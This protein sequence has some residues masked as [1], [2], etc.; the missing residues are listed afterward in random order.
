[1]PVG[2]HIVTKL[3]RGKPAI[4]YVYAWRGGPLIHRAEGKK[5]KVTTDLTDKAAEE[6]RKHNQA[7]ADTIIG[8]IASFRASAEWGRLSKSQ[9]T[10]YT[11]WL[12]RISDKFGETPLAVFS[13][14]R[15]RADVLEW[16]DQWAHQ[17]RSADVAIQTMSRLLSFGFDRGRLPSNVI[18]GVDRLYEADRSDVIWEDQ[19]IAAIMPHAAVEVQ[20]AIQLALLTGLRRG[21]LIALPWDAVGDHAILWRT[22]KSG[23]RAFVTIPVIEGLHALLDRIKDRHA[24][25]MAGKRADLRK[26]LP[27]TILSN[28]HWKPWTASGFGSRFNDAKLASKVDRNFHDLRGTYATRCM[29]AGLTDQ[30][31]ADIL[32]WRSEEVAVI[33]AKYVDQARVVIELGKRIAATK[34]G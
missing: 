8:L 26:P 34:L 28:S 24:A 6:R 22:A 10:T 9:Q 18:A 13:D 17:P 30:Q 33:R 23:R 3:R 5:P 32:G 15:V 2:L 29:V 21:D 31:I 20:E 11:T 19:H 1:M 25:A 12:G 27:D 7:P 4:Y 14:R 16:R